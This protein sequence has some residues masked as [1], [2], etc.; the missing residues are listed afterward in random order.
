[1]ILLLQLVF[2]LVLLP[3]RLAA[4]GMKLLLFLAFLVVG[5]PLLAIA[6]PLL[7]V[8]AVLAVVAAPIV[9]V[10]WGISS[11]G[12]STPKSVSA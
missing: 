8:L 4:A 10:I 1:M 12:R 7:A 2:G 11:L 3:F 5:I 9:L 6:G